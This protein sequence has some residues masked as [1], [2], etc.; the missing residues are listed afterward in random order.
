MDST[1]SYQFTNTATQTS[2][3]SLPPEAMFGI[4][5][6]SLV[7]W[8]LGIVAM[9]KIFT[10]ASKPGW[11]SIVPFYNTW[12]LAE[13]GGKP[14]WWGLVAILV[15]T[16]PFLG[17]IISIILMLLISLGVAKNFGKST[18]FGIIGLFLFSIVGYLIL[19]FG[20]A[21]YQAVASGS[22]TPPE[23]SGTPEIFN[24]NPE[25]ANTPPSTSQPPQNPPTNLVQ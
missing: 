19:A 8:L 15:S 11:A 20:S 14:G 12:V 24:A 16:V 23:N 3:T 25:N 17:A 9:W 5:A 21:K 18:V 22:S 1:N 6:I 10:K 7:F 4:I 13:V 2:G